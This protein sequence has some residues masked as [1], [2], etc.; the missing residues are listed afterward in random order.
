MVRD[1]PGRAAPHEPRNLHDEVEHHEARRPGATLWAV[2]GGD[3]SWLLLLRLIEL[4]FGGG[5]LLAQVLGAAG[6][7]A[8]CQPGAASSCQ[9]VNVSKQAL[10]AFAQ[11]RDLGVWSDA[12]GI[13][14]GRFL[15]WFAGGACG[16]ELGYIEGGAF[17]IAWS[18]HLGHYSG[19][20][21]GGDGC[22][23]LGRVLR[24]RD[25]LD[26]GS[27]DGAGQRAQ[28]LQAVLEIDLQ[29]AAVAYRAQP[30]I[31]DFFIAG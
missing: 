9:V 1:G 8:G 2:G 24:I 6:D 12:V 29:T 10:A 21:S 4:G 7:C 3:G 15:R 20:G 19:G 16:G 22:F 31:A 23:G 17:A 11:S 5:G 27:Q 28:V 26:R 18:V 14:H 25:F 13:C 30:A